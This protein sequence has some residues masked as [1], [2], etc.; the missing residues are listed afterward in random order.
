MQI[1]K[2]LDLRTV[3]AELFLDEFNHRTRGV[4]FRFLDFNKVGIEVHKHHIILAMKLELVF[5]NSTP[6]AIWKL[7]TLHW[8][9]LILS[10]RFVT[11]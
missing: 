6:R 4:L 9:L 7:V 10:L 3:S 8:K 1:D 11:D 5:S 2:T